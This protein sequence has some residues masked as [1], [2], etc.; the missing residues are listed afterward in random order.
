MK[1]VKISIAGVNYSGDRKTVIRL[2]RQ[3]GHIVSPR[4]VPVEDHTWETGPRVCLEPIGFLQ[5]LQR[6]A[7][8]YGEYYLDANGVE[9][10]FDGSQEPV[11]YD[12][13]LRPLY[14]V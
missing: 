14:A 7:Q 1:K 9:V 10:I 11:A 13:D 8:V 4:M 5:P 12:E 2:L 3:A 6:G